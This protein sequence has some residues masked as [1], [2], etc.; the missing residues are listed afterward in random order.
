MK[1]RALIIDGYN[2]A[3]DGLMTLAK[4]SV[5]TPKYRAV[6]QS[7]PG[8]D[9]ALDYSDA[10]SGRPYYETRKLTASLESSAGT[11]EERQARFDALVRHCNGR[12]CRIVSPDYPGCYYIGRVQASIAFN[13]PTYGQIDLEAVC[14]PWRYSEAPSV[15]NLPV[16]GP[17]GDALEGAVIFYMDEVSTC[18]AH[19]NAQ[20]ANLAKGF[21]IVDGDVGSTAVWCI[22]LAP[23][24][25]YYASGRIR[26]GRG[27]WGCAASP[28]AETWQ[29]GAVRTGDD[30]CLYFRI[31]SYCSTMVNV[32]PVVIV[33]AAQMHIASNGVAPAVATVNFASASAA[34][35]AMTITVCVGSDAM[36]LQNKGKWEVDLPPGD[37]P[38]LLYTWMTEPSGQTIPISWTRGDF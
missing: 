1:R 14:E 18:R 11:H 5:E 34:I 20:T 2:T 23:N 26:D 30:G 29:K 13:K 24:T 36:P 17:S 9:G 4:F 7:V 38:V 25:D 22:Q 10:L 37:V 8:M 6:T 27:T 21:S 32:T 3:V 28:T 15:V 35:D 33:P 19:A 31:E 12:R 16:L